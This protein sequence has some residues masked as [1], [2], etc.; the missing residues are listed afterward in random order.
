VIVD[1][2]WRFGSQEEKIERMEKDVT[3]G[4]SE[5]ARCSVMIA[6]FLGDELNVNT[7]Y[8]YSAVKVDT[9]YTTLSV[10]VSRLMAVADA[11]KATPTV[12]KK[13]GC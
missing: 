3:N 5:N 8:S 13:E 12:L 4:N 9:N 7:G 2:A 11:S 1:D 6:S 10:L